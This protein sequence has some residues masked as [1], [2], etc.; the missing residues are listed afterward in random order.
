M[1]YSV[2]GL[3]LSATAAWRTHE[4]SKQ[5]PLAASAAHVDNQVDG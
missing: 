2:V 4:N 5:G 3:G 1:T